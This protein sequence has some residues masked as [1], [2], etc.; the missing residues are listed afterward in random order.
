MQVQKELLKEQQSGGAPIYIEDLVQ[1]QENAKALTIPTLKR[2]AELNGFAF[3]TNGDVKFTI[4]GAFIT[5][6]IYSNIVTGSSVTTCDVSPFTALLGD[7]V[8][9]YP[10]GQIEVVTLLAAQYS[11]IAVTAG[12]ELVESRT[13]RNGQTNDIIVTNSVVLTAMTKISGQND[14]WLVNNEVN[15]KYTVALAPFFNPEN[16]QSITSSSYYRYH[17]NMDWDVQ[18]LSETIKKA[19]EPVGASSLQI[20]SWESLSDSGADAGAILN[21]AL[22][23]SESLSRLLRFRGQI[24]L[25]NISNG[26]TRKV[27][28][29]PT[30]FQVFRQQQV[31]CVL[32]QDSTK[33]VSAYLEIRTNGGI[34]IGVN[35]NVTGS[36]TV[37][38]YLDGVVIDY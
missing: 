7:K 27:A 16:N 21:N 23:R 11:A 19:N 22:V 31:V 6:P 20:S 10:G 24:E 18:G 12:T 9:Y 4:A 30:G 36:T 35:G 25:D 3:K 26:N 14:Q 38:A 15:G 5:P 13:F 8:C 28:Q 32:P 33:T 1:V 34:Y 29:L 2:N 37:T 17:P